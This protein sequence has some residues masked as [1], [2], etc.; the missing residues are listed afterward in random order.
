MSWPYFVSGW[1]LAGAAAGGLVVLATGSLAVR[2]CR[3]PAR[4]ARLV[5]LTVAGALAVPWF[6]SLGVGLPVPLR[7]PAAPWRVP[8]PSALTAGPASAQGGLA[9]DPLTAADP[10]VRLVQVRGAARSGRPD[11]PAGLG[12]S[13]SAAAAAL[14]GIDWTRLAAVAYATASAGLVAWWALGQLL[15]LHMTRGARPVPRFVRS[16]FL[17][18]SGPAGERVRLLMTDRIALPFTYTWT[19]PVILLPADLCAGDDDESLLYALA[20]EW[21]HVERGDAWAWNLAAVAGALLFYQPLYWWLRR[22]L[23]LS[24]DYLADDRAAAAGTP[25]DYA[26]CLI[27][28]AR[29]GARGRTLGTALPAVGIFDQPSNLSRRVHMLLNDRAPI[30]RRCPRIWSL[31]AFAAA[32]LAILAVAGLRADATPAPA[33]DEPKPSA[34]N[35]ALPAQADAKGEALRYTGKVK[36]RETGRPIAGASVVVRREVAEFATGPQIIA[37]TRHTTDADGAFAFTIPPEQVAEKR[38]YLELD[39]EHPDYASQN[40]FGYG[41]S[42]IRRDEARG[43]RPFF[44]NI[45]LRPAKPVTG[46]VETPDGAPAEG[47]EVIATSR[48]GKPQNGPFEPSATTRVRTDRDGRFRVPVTTP[49]LGM[50]WI[51]PDGLAPESR[52]IPSDRRGDFGPFTLQPGIALQGRAFDAKGRPIGGMFLQ[53]DRNRES[54]PDREILDMLSSGDHIARRAETDAEGRFAFGPLPPGV[55]VVQPTEQHFVPGKGLIH[56][57]LPGVFAAQKLTLKEGETPRPLEIRALP[58]VVLGGGWVDSKGRPRG[59]SSLIVSGTLDGQIWS[60]IVHPSADG[61]FSEPVPHGMEGAQ[62]TMFPGQFNSTR[63][64]TGKGQKL[65]AGQVLMLGTL[66]R[67]LKDIELIRYDKTGVIVKATAKDGRPIKDFEVGGEYTEE[68]ANAGFRIGLKNGATTEVMFNRQ[69]DGRL[70]SDEIVPD[71]A[72][73]IT[74]YADGFKPASRQVKLPEGKVEE[75]TVALEPK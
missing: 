61:K 25:E 68:I 55:Y 30:E 52:A 47:V 27:R 74:A 24:Q 8:G 54:A 66:D 56:R 35:A 65:E 12:D 60:K 50:L 26:A 57:P 37:E 13:T 29:L 64:R 43:Q 51:V 53:I 48:P 62:I 23:R 28:L 69:D 16:Q 58:Y 73:K 41:L 70:R 11:R 21:S 67:D 38:L 42:L 49:G 59:G 20:H 75:I 10:E 71:R 22:Q 9:H 6:G 33:P 46:R 17:R 19:R 63:F 32:V 36:D 31:G 7:L 2:L 72:V 45:R 44:E 34:P 39:V 5:V 40:G 14:A 4:R 1:W 18:V 3:Q 15:L